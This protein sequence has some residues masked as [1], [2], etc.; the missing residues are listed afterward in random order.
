M[1]YIRRL[2]SFLMTP[3]PRLIVCLG[4]GW[5]I[6]KLLHLDYIDDQ[7]WYRPATSALLAVGLYASTHGIVIE[8]VK[9]H[10]R[11]IL[12]AVTVGVIAKAFITGGLLW[13]L[14]GLPVFFVLG[15]NIA[16][17]DPLAVAALE[18]T[19]MSVLAMSLLGAWSSF[20]DPMTV[21]LGLYTPPL[22]VA[23]APGAEPIVAGGL[24]GYV[25]ALGLNLA[26]ALLVFLVWKFTRR[27]LSN[28]LLVLF[29]GYALLAMSFATAI[30]CLM[31]LGLAI[32]GLF[33]RPEKFDRVIDAA[34]KVALV[35]AT[36]LLGML[37]VYGINIWFG[38]MLGV[39][40]YFAHTLV[41]IPLTRKLPWADRVNL[42]FAQQNGITAIILALLFEPSYPGTVAIIAPAIVVINTLHAIC[43]KWVVP[44]VIALRPVA[45]A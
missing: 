21:L 39:V 16:Q 26:F 32:I 10:F 6:A 45:A 29:A 17:V 15:I 4:V 35:L 19:K 23:P 7:P 33:L 24:G 8:Q 2:T 42:A 5:F 3:L 13:G 22:M 12:L 31:M 41:A 34:V 44:R 27:S 9:K 14:T 18:K 1:V 40:G 11:L 37:L 25:L 20:D 38:L 30:M 28:T 43:N 36:L